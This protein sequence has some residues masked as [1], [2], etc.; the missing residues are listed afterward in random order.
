[1]LFGVPLGIVLGRAVWSFFAHQLGVVDV[2]VLPWA[3]I[4][5]EVVG[6]LVLVNLIALFPARRIA[7]M[8]AAKTLRA[9]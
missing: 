3:T 2:P 1:M 8:N 9:T 7:L 6:T 4:T 5:I